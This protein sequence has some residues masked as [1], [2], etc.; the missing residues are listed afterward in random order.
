MSRGQEERARARRWSGRAGS[1]EREGGPRSTGAGGRS[2]LCSAREGGRRREE[3]EGKEKKENGKEKRKRRGE[4]REKG[5]RERFAVIPPVA[6]A[7]PV[8]HARL[9]RPRPLSGVMHG[10]RGK[11]GSGYGCRVFG[12]SGDLAEQGRFR[13]LGLGFG[14]SSSTTKQN[15]SA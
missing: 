5:E 1:G 14:I 13:K 15:F 12:G 3:G 10:L 4:K 9:S 11:Q 6:T 7:T 2:V 8:G